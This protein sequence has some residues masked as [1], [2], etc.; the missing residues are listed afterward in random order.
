[1]NIDNNA[2]KGNKKLTT[3]I[4]NTTKLTKKTVAKNAFKGVGNKV[5]IKV[6]KNKKKAYIKLFRI[7]GLKKAVK[8]K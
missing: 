5:R 4:I 2:F 8:F 1:M 7:K 3:I 6:P